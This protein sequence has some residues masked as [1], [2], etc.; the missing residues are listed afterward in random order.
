MKLQTYMKDGDNYAN[1]FPEIVPKIEKK[2][3]KENNLFQLNYKNKFVS[4][5]FLKKNWFCDKN[6]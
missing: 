6:S 3:C 5:R 2:I 4:K 1:C